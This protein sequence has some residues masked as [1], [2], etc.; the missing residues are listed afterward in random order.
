MFDN[1]YASCFV[2]IAVDT[3][4]AFRSS[5]RAGGINDN[6]PIT[7][8][9]FCLI[10]ISV[11]II[12]TA[13]TGMHS[14][15]LVRTRRIGYNRGV[16]MSG[17]IDTSCF[18]VITVFT[19]AAFH[20]C[21]CASWN[22]NDNP[23]SK[24][25]S[26]GFHICINIIEATFTNMRGV[27]LSSTGRGRNNGC[28]SMSDSIQSSCFILITLST[29]TTLRSRG[30]ACFR[31][32]C[33]PIT[34]TMPYCFYISVNIVKS[35]FTSMRG[36]A[37]SCASRRGD[38]RGIVMSCSVYASYFVM[39]TVRTIT[40][41][42]AG[43]NTCFRGD[44]IP[45]AITMS[46]S[47]Y[48]CVNI[49]DS[50]F[51]C[52]RG[53]ALIRT[54]GI[55][56]YSGISMSRSFCASYFVV[57]TVRTITAL[58]SGCNTCF[59]YDSIPLTTSMSNS[60]YICINIIDSAF[61]CMRGIALIRTRRIR[62]YRGVGMSCS[63]EASYFVVITISTIPTLCSSCNTCCHCDSIPSAIC[64]TFCIRIC[65]NIRS[66]ARTSMRCITLF[67][68]GGRGDYRGIVMSCSVYI[69]YFVMIAISTIPAF[70][71]S[72]HTCCRSD[73]IPSA[74]CMTF[75]IHISINIRSSA[76]T[77]IRCITLFGAGGRGDY[78]GIVMSCSIETSNFVVI[79]VR[80]IT[81]F[82]SRS[83]TRFRRDC[84]PIT[85]AM[86]HCIHICID[87]KSA[88]HASMGCIPLVSTRRLRYYR[89]IRMS[90]SIDNL[91][92]LFST[93]TRFYF[94]SCVCTGSCESYLPFTPNMSMIGFFI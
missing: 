89:S 44:S 1:I 77:S 58:C 29:I 24:I 73:S 79:T 68:A 26:H 30:H 12:N 92:N 62:Y 81:A 84:V 13:F 91:Q 65:I 31:C 37:L 56:Y 9:M 59:C 5:N 76:D 32:N 8:N 63:I 18:I 71:S 61:T 78:R 43:C 7:K 70:C 57:I 6:N 35:A 3:I 2:M 53:V 49:I 51:T 94:F 10:H 14:I 72:S 39:I 27:A 40:A 87:I 52:M 69:S 19:I 93:C 66:S 75:C 28:I 88:T 20:S 34:K 74:I 21:V 48:I 23:I 33:I 42:R 64:M 80:T 86:P 83:H 22:C 4:T 45:R 67:G 90:F 36:V 15:T 25:V 41:L 47:I 17:S 55:R 82:R 54:R 46:N 16:G 50:A 85:V 60:I 38:Y 11:N